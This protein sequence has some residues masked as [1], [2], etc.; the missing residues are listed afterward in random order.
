MYKELTEQVKLNNW[1]ILGY[2]TYRSAR[3]RDVIVQ[4]PLQ[5]I[6][7]LL[8]L[9]KQDNHRVYHLLDTEREVEFFLSLSDGVC[10]LAMSVVEESW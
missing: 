7:P 2:Y 10:K 1:L 9:V 6:E 4:V 8:Q 5:L 3:I